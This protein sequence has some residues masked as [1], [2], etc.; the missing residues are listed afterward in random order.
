MES[1]EIRING[2][3]LQIQTKWSHPSD[4]KMP[5]WAKL[6]PVW[7]D[8]TPIE[9]NKFLVGNDFD[10]TLTISKNNTVVS[11]LFE[12]KITAHRQVTN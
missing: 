4:I 11:T 1:F 10:L 12:S 9:D 5:K 8:L 3:D 2:K 6:P 7:V